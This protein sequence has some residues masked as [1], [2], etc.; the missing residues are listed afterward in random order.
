LV[1]SNYFFAGAL[2]M[3]Y[4]D[5]FLNKLKNRAI[6]IELAEGGFGYL[7]KIV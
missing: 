7:L 1:L 4:I 5:A 3:S 6:I 2:K